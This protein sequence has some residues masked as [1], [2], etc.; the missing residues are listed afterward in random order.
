[1][2]PN[3]KLP[4]LTGAAT[5]NILLR[6]TDLGLGAVWCGIHPM[7]T[8][9]KKTREILSIPEKHIPLNIIYIGYP[10]EFP[11]ARDQFREDKIHFIK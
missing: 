10:E 11:E 6:A 2:P 8:A 4:P 1:M 9:E 7:K 5:E 3:E